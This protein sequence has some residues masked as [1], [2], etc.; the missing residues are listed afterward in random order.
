MNIDSLRRNSFIETQLYPDSIIA[1]NADDSK[2]YK[3]SYSPNPDAPGVIIIN[4][5]W[6]ELSGYWIHNSKSIM[7]YDDKGRE[8]YSEI[9]SWNDNNWQ[10]VSKSIIEYDANGNQIRGEYYYWDF[11]ASEWAGTSLSIMLYDEKNRI[12]VYESYIWDTQ[13]GRWVGMSKGVNEYDEYGNQTV[14]DSYLWGD[15]QNDW[16][17]N[18]KN[19]FSYLADGTIY[20]KE[21]YQ[22]DSYADTLYLVDIT[23]STFYPDGRIE[24]TMNFYRNAPDEDLE[25]QDKYSYLYDGNKYLQSRFLYKWDNNQQIFLDF[26]KRAY[27]TN[28]NGLPITEVGYLWRNSEWI[29]NDSVGTI[30]DAAN[31]IV[32]Q[33]RNIWNTSSNTWRNNSWNIT[34]YDN[35]GN[36]I[37]MESYIWDLSIGS[38]RGANKMVYSYDS[39]NNRLLFEQYRWDT[40]SRIFYVTGKYVNEFDGFNNMIYAEYYGWNNTLNALVGTE[41]WESTYNESNKI[42]LYIRYKWDQTTASWLNNN[43]SENTYDEHGN[44]VINSLSE[45]N[46]S[47]SQWVEN[48]R[49]INTYDEQKRIVRTE[50]YYLNRITSELLLNQYTIS[51]FTDLNVSDNNLSYPSTGGEKVIHII[52]NGSWSVESESDWLTITPL[53]ASGNTDVYIIASPN[54]SAGIRN[55]KIEIRSSSSFLTPH[56]IQVSQFSE[57]TPS[58]VYY[59]VVVIPAEGTVTHPI[60]GSY[61]T[62]NGAPFIL[63]IYI[64]EGYDASEIALR[65]NDSIYIPTSYYWGFSYTIPAVKENKKIE[66]IGLKVAPVNN[67]MM[68]NVFNVYTSKNVL[69]I[70]SPYSTGI[71]IYTILGSYYMYKQILPGN[72]I[73]NLPTGVYIIVIDNKSYKIVIHAIR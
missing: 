31:R 29:P 53:S 41:K 72:N 58:P 17:P 62:E 68:N 59:D 11:D 4:D 42:V 45:W 73:I 9:Y 70:H 18:H 2:V 50:Y 56:V 48:T 27:T 38:W 21:T 20:G 5:Y 55:A 10:G 54:I 61:L 26:E 44:L 7:Q 65:I 60:S 30:Y 49:I 22:L 32:E 24:E 71:Y 43:R 67:E 16:I 28:G 3:E 34:H 36:I 15:D 25:L 47:I 66:I 46:A 14:Y 33:K 37:L 64:N 63:D 19:R 40:N 13:K 69:Y 8:T 51:Y 12:L 52:T 39:K 6:D 1:Y 23:T 35:N 57:S